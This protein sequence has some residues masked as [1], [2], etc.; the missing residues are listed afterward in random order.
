VERLHYV[1]AE[2]T[3]CIRAFGEFPTLLKLP[4]SE[5]GEKKGVRQGLNYLS[6]YGKALH[7]SHH[8]FKKKKSSEA[9]RGFTGACSTTN[10]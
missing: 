4:S 1:K 10:S 7:N 9:K 3:G 2:C 5:E 8:T 6:D